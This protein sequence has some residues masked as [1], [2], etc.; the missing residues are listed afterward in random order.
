MCNIVLLLILIRFGGGCCSCVRPF[1][2]L[3]FGCVVLCWCGWVF[4][5]GV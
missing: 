3:G 5:G 1:V 2:S 4:A